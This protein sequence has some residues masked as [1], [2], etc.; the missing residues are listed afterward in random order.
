MPVSKPIAVIG[1]GY[2]GLP[3]S[4]HFAKAGVRVIGFDTDAKKCESLNIGQSYIS[5]I[6][7]ERIAAAVQSKTFSATTNFDQLRDCSAV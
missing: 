4:L 7:A 6:P 5:H 2:V 1:L 3:L